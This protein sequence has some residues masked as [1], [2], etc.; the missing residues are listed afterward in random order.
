[1]HLEI[2]LN[3]KIET[4]KE[5]YLWFPL[6]KLPMESE[7]KT[8][9]SMDGGSDGENKELIIVQWVKSFCVEEKVWRWMMGMFAQHCIST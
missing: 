3:G 9:I 8:E 4:Q 6:Y 1:M 5:K 7:N 2:I